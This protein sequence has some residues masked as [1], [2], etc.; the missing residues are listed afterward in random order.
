MQQIEPQVT[1]QRGYQVTDPR[2][3][4][5]GRRDGGARGGPYEGSYELRRGYELPLVSARPGAEPPR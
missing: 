5:R 2:N 3:A 4:D 1:V